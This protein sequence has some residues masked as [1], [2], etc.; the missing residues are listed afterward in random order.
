MESTLEFESRLRRLDCRNQFEPIDSPVV[1][2]EICERMFEFGS[3][4]DR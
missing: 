3:V 1:S 2:D 4:S